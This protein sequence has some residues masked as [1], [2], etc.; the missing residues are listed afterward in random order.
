V[1]TPEQKSLVKQSFESLMPVSRTAAGL[2][3]KKLFELEPSLRHM[4]MGDMQAQERKFVNMLK[5]V[6]SNLDRIEQVTPAIEA[7]GRRHAGY[8]VE[9]RHYEIFGTALLWAV[10][11]A[12]GPDCLS[13]TREAWFALYSY[14]TETMKNA[15]ADEMVNPPRFEN[16]VLM[17]V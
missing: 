17:A 16:L 13:G 12:A 11:Q 6:V 1:L 7:L 14:L 15:G 9:A 10:E 4:F 5:I 8:G 3:Y 2:F